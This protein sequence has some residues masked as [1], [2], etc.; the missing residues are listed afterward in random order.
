[1]KI[2]HLG[3]AVSSLDK[4]LA[5]YCDTLGLEVSRTEDVPSEG[6]RVAFLPAGEPRIELLEA[7]GPESPV[8]R[9]IAKKGEGIHHVCFEVADV[10][11]AVAGIRA[12]GGAIIEPA[13]RIGAGGRRIAFVHPRSTH[14]VLVELK[15]GRDDP[16]P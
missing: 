6:V 16:K 5:F 1:V 10:E 3:L 11:A 15:E 12:R 2:H 4:A 14:G 7:L 8:A 13:I 9:F